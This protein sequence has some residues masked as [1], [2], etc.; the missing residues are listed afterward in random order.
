MPKVSAKTVN[1]QIRAIV[2]PLLCEAGFEKFTPRTAW[3]RTMQA[4]AVVNFQSFN[5]YT[6]SVIGCTTHSFGVNLGIHYPRAER[7]DPQLACGLYPQEHRCAAR[8]QLEKTIAQPK[9]RRCDIWYVEPAGGNL[10]QV[11]EDAASVIRRVGLRWLEAFSDPEQAL[12]HC[13]RRRRSGNAEYVPPLGT[14]AAAETGSAIALSLDK[15]DAARRLWRAVLNEPYYGKMAD[16]I[17][18][19]EYELARLGKRGG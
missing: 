17:A 9:L 3:R 8:R 18:R 2:W 5:S 14:L 11:I 6:A 16:V 15:P 10:D 13:L 19:A 1:G 12:A 7:Y 4:V